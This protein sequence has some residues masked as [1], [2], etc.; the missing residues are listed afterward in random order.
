MKR[1]ALGL[2]VAAATLYVLAV[3][4]QTTRP[5]ATWSYLAAF[6]EAAMVGAVADWFAVVALFRHPLGLP[7][8]HT[9]IIPENKDRIGENLANF[10]CQHFLSTEQV[11][12]K[13]AQLDVPGKL[14]RWLAT[15]AHAERVSTQL[16]V[17]AQWALRA[18]ATPQVRD[19]VQ[20]LAHKGLRRIAIAPLTGQVLSGMTHDGRHQQLLDAVMLQVATW[21]GKEGVQEHVTEVI[22][23]ELRTLRYVGLDQVAARM[24]TGKLVH[25]VANT[26]RDM[27][28]DPQ[29]ELRQRFDGFAQDF[30]QRLQHDPALHERVSQWRDALLTHPAVSGYVQQLWDEFLQWLA[31]D[32]A[33]P[34]SRLATQVAS[35]VQAI[36]E[37]LKAD[38]ALRDWLQAELLR[39]APALVDRHRDDIRRYIVARVHQWNAQELSQEL[40]AH[41]GRDLQFIRINGT[42]V[43][44]LIGVLIHALTQAALAL[45][46]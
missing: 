39:A 43:G 18:L 28:D 25:A 7:I 17:V 29:H 14:A 45:A 16:T 30:V 11:L 9:A 41:I 24:A 32:L 36:G 15:P 22:A 1:L 5:H 34:D 3:V 46:A 44:G 40:E 13:L 26:L 4:L 23:K 6:A 31:Q 21:L 2:L 33:Q 8:P 10:L 20:Q 19:F 38:A 27:V 35:I 42:L 12:G 37:H